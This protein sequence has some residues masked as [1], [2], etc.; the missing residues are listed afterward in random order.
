MSA[1]T[2]REGIAIVMSALRDKSTRDCMNAPAPPPIPLG[3]QSY[4]F[5]IGQTYLSSAISPIK[6][7]TPIKIVD[8]Y[9]QHGYCYYRDDKGMVHREKDLKNS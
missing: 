6:E 1:E 2:Q 9:M 4:K 8:R 5:E 7:G 3:K